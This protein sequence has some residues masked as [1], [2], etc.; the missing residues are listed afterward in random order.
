MGKDMTAIIFHAQ[1]ADPA[2]EDL[3]DIGSGADLGGGVLSS[4]SD[5]LAHQSIPVGRGV[6]HHLLG[7]EVVAGAAALDHVAGQGEGRS[8]EA[9]DGDAAGE[10]LR[11]QAYRFGDIPEFSGAVGA[12]VGYVF[13]RANRLL[14]D[15]AFSGR[16]MKRQAHDLEGEQEVGEDDG[17]VDSKDF[18][19]GDGDFGG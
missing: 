2:V 1:A 15:G 4:D 6:V 10:M 18:G 5:Q 3:D 13:L 12:E 19:G 17:S 11:D 14:D 9:D 16:E 7:V 8:A